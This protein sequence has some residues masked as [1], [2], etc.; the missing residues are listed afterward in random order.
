MIAPI[1]S[2]QQL[3]V[4]DHFGIRSRTTPIIRAMNDIHDEDGWLRHD[5]IKEALFR[6]KPTAPKRMYEDIEPELVT[7]DRE[8]KWI[9]FLSAS[10]VS[11]M[12]AF[13]IN[14]EESG[15]VRIGNDT[16]DLG[17]A[18]HTIRRGV[19]AGKM[20]GFIV[21]RVGWREI[22]FGIG[23]EDIEKLEVFYRDLLFGPPPGANLSFRQKVFTGI[24]SIVLP[25]LEAAGHK[26]TLCYSKAEMLSDEK[27]IP[28]HVMY[29]VKKLLL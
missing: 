27:G 2:R 12:D 19:E 29:D 26:N 20:D 22:Y 5:D 23:Q 17:Y 13:S 21:E 10:M 4:M 1:Y 28:D 24:P 9:V 25:L 18:N 15:Y 6:Y 11:I 14:A 16:S 8:G 3:A 7:I